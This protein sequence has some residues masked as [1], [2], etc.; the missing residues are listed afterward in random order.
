MR[1]SRDWLAAG[2]HTGG[3]APISIVRQFVEHKKTPNKTNGKDGIAF[4][5][6]LL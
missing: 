4:R 6:I 5:A 3:G 1:R 2:L